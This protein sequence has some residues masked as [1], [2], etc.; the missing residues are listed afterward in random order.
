MFIHRLDHTGK[1]QQK[2]DIFIGSVAGIQQI[3]AIIRGKRPVIMLPGTVYPGEGL[4]VKQAG[5]A[6]A[7]RY[8]F[9]GFH[10]KLVMVNCNIGRLVNCRQLVLRRSH[11]VML[12]LRRHS[13]LPQFFIH[14]L[15]ESR[16]SLPD[17]SKVMIV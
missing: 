14:I 4:L 9:H 5:K 3:Y 16:D 8:L 17:G 15:H 2:L 6:M 11:L 7:S 13:N 12:R 10:H 1:H